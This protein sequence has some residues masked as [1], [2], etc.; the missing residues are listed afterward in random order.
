MKNSNKLLLGLFTFVVIFILVVNFAFKKQ[1]DTN[2]K[3]NAGIQNAGIQTNAPD[4]ASTFKSDSVA[5]D[6]A[7]RN[8]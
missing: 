4:S 2:V 3:S 5:M 8:E 1:M 6:K 7:I